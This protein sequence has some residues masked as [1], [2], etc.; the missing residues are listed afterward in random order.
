MFV[1]GQTRFDADGRSVILSGFPGEDWS[2]EKLAGVLE[3]A[4]AEA[5]RH[6]RP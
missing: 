3:H 2:R 4:V 6:D 1:D 5:A